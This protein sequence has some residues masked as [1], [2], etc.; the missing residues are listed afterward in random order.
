MCKVTSR[1]TL[2]CRLTPC[3]SRC[4]DIILRSASLSRLSMNDWRA[5]TPLAQLLSSLTE[6]QSLQYRSDPS[7]SS[8][9]LGPLTWS[10]WNST[11]P[12]FHIVGEGQHTYQPHQTLPLN[13]IFRGAPCTH[14]FLVVLTCPC[15]LLAISRSLNFISSLHLPDFK[16]TSSPSSHLNHPTYS[17]KNIISFASLLGGPPSMGYL[18]PFCC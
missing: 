4:R 16:L 1:R 13:C 2:D 14:S 10:W 11:S 3:P 15:L 6:K 9:K 17:L 7:L 18:K 5:W 8:W 12:H